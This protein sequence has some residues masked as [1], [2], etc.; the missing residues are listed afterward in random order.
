M[1]SQNPAYPLWRAQLAEIPPANRQSAYRAIEQHIIEDEGVEPNSPDMYLAR[2]AVGNFTVTGADGVQRQG[3]PIDIAEA[4]TFRGI[5]LSAHKAKTVEDALSTVM[6]RIVR[7]W[8]K[9]R[10]VDAESVPDDGIRTYFNHPDFNHDYLDE[11]QE[12]HLLRVSQ[13]AKPLEEIPN[14]TPSQQEVIRAAKEA[15]DDL[16]L[17][18]LKFAAHIARRYAKNREDLADLVQ[19]ANIGLIKAARNAEPGMNARFVTYAGK[20]IHGEISQYFAETKSG[21]RIKTGYAQTMRFIRDENQ[22]TERLGRKP[23]TQELI[24]ADE[25]GQLDGFDIERLRKNRALL[26]QTEMPEGWKA[27]QPIEELDA[28]H[29][30]VTPKPPTHRPIEYDDLADQVHQ[31]LLSQTIADVLDTLSYKEE[32][33]I[34]MRFGLNEKEQPMSLSE[35]G[36]VFGVTAERVRQ[37]QMKTLKKLQHPSRSDR[38]RSFLDD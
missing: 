31:E 27:E 23:T 11:E 17:H 32:D 26:F 34:R 29:L 13:R 6:P 5:E 38:I 36:E 35:I 37:I 21:V 24:D 8:G 28:D 3:R 33:V 14:P 1:N 18:N 9:H 7:I 16:V 22:L 12:Q 15:R 20:C 10:S 4:A 25:T 19:A 2:L 30:T